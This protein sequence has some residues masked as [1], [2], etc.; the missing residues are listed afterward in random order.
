[1]FGKKKIRSAEFD[2]LKR[3]IENRDEIR[4]V[5]CLND[6]FVSVQDNL[7]MKSGK[8]LKLYGLINQLGNCS[9]NERL[10][11]LKKIGKAL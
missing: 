10:G 11:Y 9:Q 2:E 5:V 8:K 1:M 3:N 7:E 6:F 4:F